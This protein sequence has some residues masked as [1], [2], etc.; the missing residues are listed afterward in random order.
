MW[1]YSVHSVKE[2][3]RLVDVDCQSV[4]VDCQS[5]DVDCQSVDKDCQSVDVDCQSEDKDWQL[6]MWTTNHYLGTA[7]Q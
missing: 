5:V 1:T 3:W 2:A 6:V 4:D 7:I